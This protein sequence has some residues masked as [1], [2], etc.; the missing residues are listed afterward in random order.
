MT[1]FE[2]PVERLRIEPHPNADALEIGRCA[3]DRAGR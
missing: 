3:R 1:T 2:V